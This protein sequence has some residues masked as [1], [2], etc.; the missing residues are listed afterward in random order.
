MRYYSLFI[1]S[2][3]KF[4]IFTAI[5]LYK[6]SFS[7]WLRKP[8]KFC[9]FLYKKYPK[10]LLRN[11]M[12]EQQAPLDCSSSQ[13]WDSLAFHPIACTHWHSWLEVQSFYFMFNVQYLWCEKHCNTKQWSKPLFKV[14]EAWWQEDKHGKKTNMER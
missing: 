5:V 2:H 10:K 11:I 4:I 7:F 1:P 13:V 8:E 3:V 12:D 14:C 6:M 9:C